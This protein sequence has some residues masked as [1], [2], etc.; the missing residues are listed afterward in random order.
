MP[1]II[2]AKSRQKSCSVSR[3]GIG[4]PQTIVQQMGWAQGKDKVE[5]GFIPDAKCVLISKP[6]KSP[7][8]FL[9]AYANTRSRTGARIACQSFCRNYL[10]ALTVLPNRRLTPVLFSD[11][12]YRV[13]LILEEL[14]WQTEEFSKKGVGNVS[15]DVLGVYQ[16]LGRQNAILRIGEGKVRERVNAHLLDHVRFLSVVKNFRYFQIILKEDAEL[17]ERIL[18]A[19][20][21]AE[22]G[23]LPPLNDIRS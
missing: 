3:A 7:D 13:A 15:N 9:V 5:I 4:I 23:V 17:L 22:T 1:I 21:E 16:L 14:P 8:A 6:S 19:K 12:K 20:Y 2:S 11:E 10:S 18:I